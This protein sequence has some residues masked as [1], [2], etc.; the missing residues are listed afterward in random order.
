MKRSGVV[1]EAT[2]AFQT[3]VQH[4]EDR[5]VRSG[6]LEYA[7][8]PNADDYTEVYSIYLQ[9]YLSAW[10]KHGAGVEWSGGDYGAWT[11]IVVNIADTVMRGEVSCDYVGPGVFEYDP[12]EPSRAYARP[13]VG[14]H[15]PGYMGSDFLDPDRYAVE[16]YRW[17]RR[18]MHRLQEDY[19]DYPSTEDYNF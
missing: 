18:G 9:T 7:K 2:R 4:Y 1:G 11:R 10:L 17:D 3:F 12:S 6:A 13:I 16:V 14:I 5:D 8:D 15:Q 19:M